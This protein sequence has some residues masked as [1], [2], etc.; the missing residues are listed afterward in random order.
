MPATVG[1]RR[2]LVTDL[3]KTL[4]SSATA[5]LLARLQTIVHLAVMQSAFEADKSIVQMLSYVSELYG[6][7]AESERHVQ[8]V[9]ERSLF[10]IIESRRLLA[11]PI[12]RPERLPSQQVTPLP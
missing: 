2:R 10:A 7:L 11:Q 3:F 5:R 12:Y 1:V 6:R 8:R 9:S 4:C